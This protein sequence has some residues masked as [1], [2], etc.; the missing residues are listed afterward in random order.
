[1]AYTLKWDQDTERLYETGVKNCALYVFDTEKSAY[2]EGVAWNGITGITETPSGAEET[3]LYAD[4][5]KYLSL[6]SKEDLGG[7]IEAYTYPDEWADCDGSAIIGG[8]K[9]GQQN[10]RTFALAYVT[11]MGNDTE[12]NGYGEKLHVIYGATASPS[13]RAYST[14]N[15]SPEAITFSWSFSTVPVDVVIDGKTYNKT[16]MVTID[17]KKADGTPTP[18]YEDLKEALFGKEGGSGDAAKATMKLPAEIYAI[19]NA[20]G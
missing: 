11:T 4:D 6:R 8:M 18:H 1:M 20:A 13:E 3:A 15:D 12:G 17:S 16:S 2:G 14:I 9:I 19:L 7:T 5:A 10:R